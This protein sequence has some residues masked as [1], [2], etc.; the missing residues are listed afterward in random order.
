MTRLF[1]LYRSHFQD[2]AF[3]TSLAL[4]ALAFIASVYAN[5]GATVY[6]GARASNSVTDIVLSNIPTFDV[7]GFFVYGAIALF[8]FIFMV[9][10]THPRHFPFTL[11]ALASLILIRAGF[12]SLTHL[13]PYPDHIPINVTSSIGI[14]FSKLFFG[15]DLFFS[16]HTAIPFMMALI[17]WH[18]AALRYIFL[19]WSVAFALTVLLGHIHY[20]IDVASAYFITYAIF[21]LVIWVFPREY[22]LFHSARHSA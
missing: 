3:V 5:Y 16:N 10:L 21:H 13:G 11:F 1:V 15:D 12:I 2:R 8:I 6:A 4:S 20:S 14:F 22:E 9:C 7:D 17:F 19:V 18:H